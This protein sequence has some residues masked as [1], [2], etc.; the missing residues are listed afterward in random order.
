[1]PA[2]IDSSGDYQI[3]VEASYGSYTPTTKTFSFHLTINKIDVGTVT[4][5]G[6]ED[7]VYANYDYIQDISL[8]FS[9]D[10]MANCELEELLDKDNL[11][12][13]FTLSGQSTSEIKNAGDYTLTLNLSDKVFNAASFTQNIKVAEYTVTVSQSMLPQE[14]TSKYFGTDDPK[15]EFTYTVNF[16]DKNTSEEI[17]IGLVRESGEASKEYSFIDISTL[18][19][20]NYKVVMAQE[21]LTFEILSSLGTLNINVTSPL[22]ITYDKTTPSLTLAYDEERGVWTIK[23]TKND[24]LSD[25]DLTMTDDSGNHAL[26]STLYKLALE[27]ISILVGDNVVK[28]ASYDKTY[29]T[30]QSG[31]GANYTKFNLTITLNITPRDITIDSVQKIFD[32]KYK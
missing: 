13:Y 27:N 12:Y 4:V 31:K 32:R 28:A 19:D 23:I 30:V 14:L 29:F 3:V 5:N 25:I 18:N 8:T 9:R 7:L 10:D 20:D 11:Y 22:A 15:F 6:I 16:T 24:S 26:N 2:N 21:G 17:T 1:M